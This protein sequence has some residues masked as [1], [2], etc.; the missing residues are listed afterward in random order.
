MQNLSLT[1]EQKKDTTERVEKATAYIKELDLVCAVQSVS[2]NLGGVDPKFNSIF[3][4]LL[5]PYLQDT[6]YSNNELPK[7]E[8]KNESPEASV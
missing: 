4:T 2:V 6:K 5:Q 8:P 7:E 3:G 1:E